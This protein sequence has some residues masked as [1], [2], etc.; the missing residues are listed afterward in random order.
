MLCV[1]LSVFPFTVAIVTPLSVPLKTVR[2]VPPGPTLYH[3]MEGLGLATAVQIKVAG[4]GSVTVNAVWFVI[5]GVAG[6]T[7]REGH[8][9]WVQIA[10]TSKLTL[11]YQFKVHC[12]IIW[13]GCIGSSALISAR[14]LISAHTQCQSASDLIHHL[15]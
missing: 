12:V 6:G 4:A 14:I 10:L 7:A 15:F 3:L 13:H 2:E 8:I 11:D 1:S 9:A 5:L